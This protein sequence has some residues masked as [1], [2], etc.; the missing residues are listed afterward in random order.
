MIGILSRQC[1]KWKH[2][3]CQLVDCIC[4]CHERIQKEKGEEKI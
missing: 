4:L 3:S 2:P 1:N